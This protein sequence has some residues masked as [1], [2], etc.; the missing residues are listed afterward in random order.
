M[1]VQLQI[2]D[3]SGSRLAPPL[4]RLL[5]RLH[6]TQGTWSIALVDDAQ[7]AD[8]HWQTLRIPSSTDVLTFDLRDQR[9]NLKSQISNLKSYEGAPLDLETVICLDETR[10]RA[11]E[12][13]HPLRHELILYCLHSLLHVQGYDDIT[14]DQCQKMHAREDEILQE[15]GI[16]PVYTKRKTPSPLRGETRR[17]R[18]LTTGS[19]MPALRLG[20]APP[21]ATIRGP[22]G[23][24]ST[25]KRH[26]KTPKH[27]SQSTQHKSQIQKRKAKREKR[28]SR[29]AA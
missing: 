18:V 12:L 22:S 3:P 7:M 6:I 24:N 9:Q 20:I 14:P 16:G 11:R 25:A 4:R 8:L 21:V 17:G 2:L 23:A 26:S 27:K 10:R 29:R 5:A 13:K 1:P 19:A 15:I 28:K